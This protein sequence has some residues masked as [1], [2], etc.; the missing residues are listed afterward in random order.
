VRA[1]DYFCISGHPGVEVRGST[2]R[3][4][5]RS[6][7]CVPSKCQ[8]RAFSSKWPRFGPLPS[9]TALPVLVPLRVGTWQKLR[10]FH[11]CGGTDLSGKSQEVAPAIFYC[12]PM[13]ADR[14]IRRL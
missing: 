10:Q 12:F 2:L 7:R 4:Q 14:A 9:P 13:R 1:G 5:R 8:Q 3:R 11:A 6:I